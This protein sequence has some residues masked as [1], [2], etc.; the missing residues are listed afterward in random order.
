[1]GRDYNDAA[2][3]SP[4]PLFGRRITAIVGLFFHI[5]DRA[6]AFAVDTGPVERHVFCGGCQ[7]SRSQKDLN[8]GIEVLF[9]CIQAPALS[10]ARPSRT[11]CPVTA[12]G[13]PPANPRCQPRVVEPACSTPAFT[14]LS[15]LTPQ[16]RSASRNC[17]NSPTSSWR[18]SVVNLADGHRAAGRANRISEPP[19]SA[20]N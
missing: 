8:N 18:H 15:A 14:G 19:R 12:P 3:I 16:V 11:G 2:V 17:K 5:E 1:M 7:L 20:V 10:A 4:D 9:S 6:L 13:S